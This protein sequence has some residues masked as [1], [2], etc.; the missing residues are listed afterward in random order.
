MLENLLSSPVCMCEYLY[1]YVF[2]YTYVH[3]V[4]V[5]FVFIMW[6]VR[7]WVFA[8]SFLCVCEIMHTYMLSIL[9]SPCLV[10][11]YLGSHGYLCI[12]M[13]VCEC[14]LANHDVSLC[15]WSLHVVW[16]CLHAWGSAWVCLLSASSLLPFLSLAGRTLLPISA[17]PLSTFSQ[18]TGFWAPVSLCQ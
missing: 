10:S 12:N 6:H 5:L 2:M 11:V 18:Q 17:P 4:S 7:L 9:M 13:S 14:M 1:G 3:A 15:E 8:V 16:P